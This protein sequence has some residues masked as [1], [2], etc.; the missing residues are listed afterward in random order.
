MDNDKPIVHPY[1]NPDSLDDR[2]F[3]IKTNIVWTGIHRI[4]EFSE[5]FQNNSD[6]DLYTSIK[7][8]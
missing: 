5:W 7:I 1:L 6:S 2:V 3:L 4:W 8:W